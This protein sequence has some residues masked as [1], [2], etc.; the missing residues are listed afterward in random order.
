MNTKDASKKLEELYTE[1]LKKDQEVVGKKSSFS[2]SFA[3]EKKLLGNKLKKAINEYNG[4]TP[5][6]TK[7][8]K[9]KHEELPYM[10]DVDDDST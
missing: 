10:V 5:G 6:T 8:I 4:Y 9:S 2:V 3:S 7:T 1:Y